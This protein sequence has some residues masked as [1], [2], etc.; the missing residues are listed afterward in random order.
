MSQFTSQSVTPFLRQYHL[1]LNYTEAAFHKETK[2]PGN[3]PTFSERNSGPP[4]YLA[5]QAQK[6]HLLFHHKITTTQALLLV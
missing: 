6:R 2:F 4:V 3:K 1:L 5:S